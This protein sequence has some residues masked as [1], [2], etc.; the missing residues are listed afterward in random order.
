MGYFFPQG[1]SWIK[2]SAPGLEPW[3]WAVNGSTS[4][5]ASV[6]SAILSL[7]GGFSLV[8]VL[9]GVIYLG[10]WTINRSRSS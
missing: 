4:V 10:A 3:A 1:M 8:L 7:Q 5:I 2:K 9:G 6:L